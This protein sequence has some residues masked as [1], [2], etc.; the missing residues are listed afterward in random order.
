[1]VSNN[2]EV[3]TAP[4]GKICVEMVA[5][6][7]YDLIL[8]DIKMPLMDGWDTF[9][10][11]SDMDPQISIIIISEYGTA[12][13]AA[14][15]VKQGAFNFISKPPDLKKLLGE[16]KSALESRKPSKKVK[17]FS[18]KRNAAIPQMI[19]QSA[20]MQLLKKRIMK[21]ADSGSKVLITSADV[22]KNVITREQQ[23]KLMMKRLIT[24]LG[25]AQ[26]VLDFIEA[27]Y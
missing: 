3:E 17:Q 12:E 14:A 7:A 19:G 23:K 9:L 4:N 8:L 1:L 13:E 25:G 24:Q 27:E 16:V 15:F 26:E 18:K 20:P 21:I 6:T 22:R 11:L 2:Y 10:R 5:K